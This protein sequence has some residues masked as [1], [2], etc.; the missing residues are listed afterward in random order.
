MTAQLDRARSW[1]D[2]RNGSVSDPMLIKRLGRVA[3]ILPGEEAAVR[4]LIRGTLPDGCI[5]DEIEAMLLDGTH[6]EL[7]GVAT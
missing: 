2:D 7:E 5:R 1:G 4:K 3:P 6:D